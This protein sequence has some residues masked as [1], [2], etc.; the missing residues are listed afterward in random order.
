MRSPRIDAFN[1]A[2]DLFIKSYKFEFKCTNHQESNCKHHVLKSS[3]DFYKKLNDVPKLNK[4]QYLSSC[5]SC[6]VHLPI[7]LMNYWDSKRLVEFTHDDIDEEAFVVL[8]FVHSLK[9]PHTV[10]LIFNSPL[11]KLLFEYISIKMDQ[12]NNYVQTHDNPNHDKFVIHYY[13]RH[14]LGILFSVS[15]NI[16]SL[17]PHHWRILMKLDHIQKWIHF[18]KF[19]LEFDN[20]KGEYRFI[21]AKIIHCVSILILYGFWFAVP[22][23]SEWKYRQELN[24]NIDYLTFR[25]NKNRIDFN[26]RLYMYKVLMRTLES[27]DYKS[28]SYEYYNEYANK[29]YKLKRNEMQCQ[30]M[31]CKKR[32]KDTDK[33]YKCKKCK[34]CRYCTRKCQKID[35]KYNHKRVCKKIRKFK[36]NKLL[37]E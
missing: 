30:N 21:A 6:I 23:N 12:L 14:L 24:V 37:R 31:K 36:R 29:V 28:K 4:K 10:K 5:K 13:Y 33:F 7:R 32:R 18:V 3:A 17:K 19:Q 8:L 27:F 15:K 22:S 34:V 26:R 1:M 2:G 35:W 11:F 20:F 25:E 16:S 9:Y